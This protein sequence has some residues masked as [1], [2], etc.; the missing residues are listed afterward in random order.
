MQQ[1]NRYPNPLAAEAHSPVFADFEV[2]PS[3]A[4]WIFHAAAGVGPLAA[5]RLIL[6]NFAAE[7]GP[8]AAGWIFHAAAGV[9]PLAAERHL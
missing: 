2:G 3:A 7:V 5:E 1:R 8:S 9:G 6:P 4:G